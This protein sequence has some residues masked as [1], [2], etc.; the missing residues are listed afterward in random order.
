MATSRT[1]AIVMAGILGLVA[2]LGVVWLVGV[3]TGGPGSST[4]AAGAGDG[5]AGDSSSSDP[6][7]TGTTDG[8]FSDDGPSPSSGVGPSSGA[9]PS[10][11]AG[12]RSQRRS[13]RVDGVRLDGNP[14]GDGC[15][16]IINKT[17]A[18]AVM[19][20]VTFTLKKSPAPVGLTPASSAC[21][22]GGDPPCEGA[23]VQEGD[24][25]LA[26]V[27]LKGRPAPGEY[28]IGVNVSYRYTCTSVEDDPCNYPSLRGVPMSPE[29][30]VDVYGTT[31]N[32]VPDI[33]IFVEGPPSPEASPPASG[34]D[35]V[36]PPPAT[37]E[38]PSPA[39][40][41]DDPA[42]EET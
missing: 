34:P 1:R 15:A 37:D 40:T 8:S 32:N 21:D 9:G 23:R 38:I 12:P 42:P 22:N 13:I 41:E 11:S 31:A 29:D 16:T 6:L 19:T 20:N 17:S 7:A 28:L 18:P 2:I 27:R 36:S 25:C 33:E 30:P 24:Q 26:G 14:T 10:S 5:Y 4:D 35:E 3:A 39:A